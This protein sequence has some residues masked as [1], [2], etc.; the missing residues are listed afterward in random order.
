MRVPAGYPKMPN[1]MSPP[2]RSTPEP[3]PID[4][5]LE[6][7]I[8]SGQQARQAAHELAEQDQAKAVREKRADTER[9]LRLSLGAVRG[10][11]KRRLMLVI[12]LVPMVATP[13]LSLVVDIGPRFTGFAIMGVV[14][15]LFGL[16][17]T[18]F[19]QPHASRA[20]VRAENARVQRL[21]YRLEGLFEVLES[22]A[23]AVRFELHFDSSVRPPDGELVHAAFCAVDPASRSERA[24]GHCLVI[25]SG[26]IPEYDRGFASGSK[27]N[28]RRQYD[29]RGVGLR[30]LS[31]VD[32]VLPPLHASFPL[33][34]V[35]LAAGT[36]A[37]LDRAQLLRLPR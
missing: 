3:P 12:A 26:E 24:N 17:L 15:G 8:S 25:W 20:M 7:L 36:K 11:L 21:P 34:R 32:R 1:G 14:Y 6:R 19:A 13:L 30:T 2:Y 31:L 18:A 5:Q 10:S 22:K 9:Q 35:V 29:D 33:T 4:P 16:L 28:M 37:D 23:R 27:H